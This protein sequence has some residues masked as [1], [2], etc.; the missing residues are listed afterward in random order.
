MKKNVGGFT[1]VE[2]I[3]VIGILALMAVGATIAIRGVIINA[4]RTALVNDATRLAETINQYNATVEH[5]NRVEPNGSNNPVI[6]AEFRQGNG[7]VEFVAPYPNN[8]LDPL[9]LTVMFATDERLDEVITFVTYTGIG[10]FVTD[11]DAI[12]AS[13]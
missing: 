4:R 3:V 6:P 7:T 11:S 8:E 2:L 9:I 5:N 10:M 1:L 13:N 12:A